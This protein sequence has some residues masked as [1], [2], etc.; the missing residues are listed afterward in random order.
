MKKIIFSITSL[1]ATAVFF[2]NCSKAG[3]E[4]YSSG[5]TAGVDSSSSLNSS[6]NEDGDDETILPRKDR[7]PDMKIS[8]VAEAL[9]ISSNESLHHVENDQSIAQM[10]DPESVAKGRCRHIPFETGEKFNIDLATG[11]VHAFSGDIAQIKCLGYK[12]LLEVKSI[13]QNKEICKNNIQPRDDQM[14][15]QVMSLSYASLVIFGAEIKLGQS[16]NGCG[17]GRV[18]LCDSK[19]SLALQ[20]FVNR[21]KQKEIAFESSEKCGVPF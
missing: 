8:A 2:Q 4:K 21:I 3:F 17:T 5:L 16:N 10:C 13:L 12:D 1:I 20:N 11:V 18:D 19:A 7:G 6:K 14:C 15:T 9:I